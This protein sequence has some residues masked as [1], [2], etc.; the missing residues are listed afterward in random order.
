MRFVVAIVSFVIAFALIG[1]GLAQ[2]T[3]FAGP[4]RVTSQATAQ[5][6][7][8]I[9]IIDGDALNVRDG[10][11]KIEVGSLL[12]EQ[13]FAAYGRTGDLVAWAG[14]TSYNYVTYD[15][16]KAELTTEF[17]R[18]STDEAIDPAGSDLWLGEYAKDGPLDF[19]VNV[20]DDISVIILADGVQPAPSAV[21]VTWSVDNRAPW[22][23]PL[24]VG[25]VLF[26]LLGLGLYLWA[27]AHLRKTRGP[28]RKPP[29]QPKLS[30]KPRYNYRKATK[31]VRGVKPKA[32]ENPRGRRS[33]RR[34]TAVLPVVLVAAVVLSGCAADDWPD[35]ITGRTA[36]SAPTPSATAAADGDGIVQAPA[37]TVPQL[38]QIVDR[39]ATVAG[40]ADADRDP[41]LAATRFA[42]AALQLRKA[43]YAIRR[44][45][46]SIA[47]PM[48]IPA[49]PVDGAL[50]QQSDTWP[51]TV[52]TVIQEAGRTRSPFPA[53]RVRPP[54]GRHLP[55]MR[56]RRR[57]PS[58]PPR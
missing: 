16:E 30:G 14:D 55:K 8:P 26:L 9:T 57:R 1:L 49:G 4:D 11:Q 39:I 32:I 33:A 12:D 2:R 53:R 46:N 5:T 54:T 43:N 27:L 40:K 20:P 34:M 7:A 17:V 23:G 18:G 19:T 37:V 28:R 45:D 24:L 21:A 52:F 36:V 22:S 50:P 47:A 56:P 15:E 41:E 44:V 58:S 29:A 31:A 48:E 35:F 10:R 51:R 3:V 38:E 6:D 13:V 42:G 25:G